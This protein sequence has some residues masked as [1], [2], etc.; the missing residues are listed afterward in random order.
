MVPRTGLRYAQTMDFLGGA[1]FP[2][3]IVSSFLC[4]WSDSNKS[5]MRL[6]GKYPFEVLRDA[7]Q[8]VFEFYQTKDIWVLE[9]W[10]IRFVIKPHEY[11]EL[12]LNTGAKQGYTS[13]GKIVLQ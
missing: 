5:T 9:L 8:G 2:S 13:F 7:M 6:F 11:I 3:S 10:Q 4:G 1:L 12:F